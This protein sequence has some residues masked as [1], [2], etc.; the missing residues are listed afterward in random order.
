ME[1]NT[2]RNRLL[3]PEYGRNIQKMVEYAIQIPDKDERTRFAFLIVSVM[4][5]VNPQETSGEDH[6][7]KLWDH[8]H[9]IA[10]FK[11]EV[12]SPYEKPSKETLN[13][14]PERVPYA[15]HDIPYRHYGKNILRIIEMATT[16]E[17][18]PEKDAF[19]K[20]IATQLKKSYLQWNRES[21][22]DELIAAQLKELSKGKL[23][24]PEGVTLL[25]TNEI[26][27]QQKKQ[28]KTQQRNN[29]KERQHKYKRKNRH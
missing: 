8:L 29:G 3:I 17:E 28:Q 26:L 23:T 11:L 18:G 20:V 22:N 15:N 2:T 13:T 9:V 5:Q 12:D 1:Y 16:L 4:D 19:I 6:L 21:V 24:L 7:H 10:D 27:S 25:S 14:K